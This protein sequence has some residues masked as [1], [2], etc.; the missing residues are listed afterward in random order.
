[1]PE[2][3]RVLEAA[4]SRHGLDFEF[5][6]FDFASCDY[7]AVHGGMI[8]EAWKARSGAILFMNGKVEFERADGR[9]GKSPG[10]GTACSRT[11]SAPRQRCC[12]A[13]WGT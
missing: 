4:A 7:Y 1:M 6:T 12:A 3:L 8:P 10:T 2:G 9:I 5:E 13:A 11:A